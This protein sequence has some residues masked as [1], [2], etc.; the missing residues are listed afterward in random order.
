MNV[1]KAEL[2][3]SDAISFP[4]YYPAL[5]LVHK[6]NTPIIH[7]AHNVIPYPV[8]PVSL[9]GM[10]AIYSTTIII[11]SFSLNSQQ[12]TLKNIILTNQCSTHR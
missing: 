12:N 2:I 4:F 8:W 6:R 9:N 11:S 5:F 3:Y 7:G 10:F 1:D